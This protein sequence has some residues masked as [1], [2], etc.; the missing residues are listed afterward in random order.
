MDSDV[1]KNLSS[2]GEHEN[3]C[4]CYPEHCTHGEDCWCSPDLEKLEDG[5]TLVIHRDVQ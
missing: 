2:G 5:T 3:V 4:K 1:C